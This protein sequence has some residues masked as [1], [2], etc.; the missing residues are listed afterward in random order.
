LTFACWF[1]TYSTA[2]QQTLISKY[3]GSAG[4]Q[5]YIMYIENSAA[6]GVYVDDGSGN[7][8]LLSS[9]GIVTTGKWAHYCMMQNQ[10]ALYGFIDGKLVTSG[11]PARNLRNSPI[12]FYVG[13]YHNGGACN[14]DMAHA[15]V[16]A[17][18]SLSFEQI[19]RLA[20]GEPPMDVQQA[21]CLG[22]WP[23]GG[24][25]GKNFAPGGVNLT[26]QG[27]L[28]VYPSAPVFATP[29]MF[30]SGGG[31][32]VMAPVYLPAMGAYYGT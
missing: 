27:S 13:R 31:E 1:K 10:T 30:V 8:S 32:A 26:V 17:G 16:W 29:D 20:A 4:E 23:M 6:F 3:G 7:T 24:Y 2:S 21:G 18:T 5:A 9:T 22:Y 25:G 28:A 14:G 12:P 19:A 11:T 15:V